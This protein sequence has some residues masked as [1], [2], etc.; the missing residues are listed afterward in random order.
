MPTKPLPSPNISPQPSTQND[1]DEI[2]KTM[3][4]FARMFVQFLA[5]HRPDST[6]AKPAFIQKTSMAATRTQRVSR[7]M[8][9][10]LSDPGSIAGAVEVASWA[11]AG[12]VAAK[13]S[14][15]QP[16]SLFSP[17]AGFDGSFIGNAAGFDWQ[18][19]RPSKRWLVLL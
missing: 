18:M 8:R 13:A 12:T 15:P 14:A 6:S 5:R 11:S 16:R 2:A 9:R 10:P 1:R 3:K 19:L 17:R 7:P 4:F